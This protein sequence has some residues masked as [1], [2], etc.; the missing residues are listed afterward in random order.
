MEFHF[1]SYNSAARIMETTSDHGRVTGFEV[2]K[3][4]G[5]S[6]VAAKFEVDITAYTTLKSQAEKRVGISDFLPVYGNSTFSFFR[7][8]RLAFIPPPFNPASPPC[9]TQ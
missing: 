6:L 3:G 1:T 5:L 8:F 2:K 9:R 4:V 7:S